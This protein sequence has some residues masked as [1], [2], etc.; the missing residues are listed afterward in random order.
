MKTILVLSANPEGTAVLELAREV[1]DIRKAL[2]R[3]K[4][5]DDFEL[6]HRAEV[7]WKDFR[8]AIDDLQPEIVHFSGHGTGKMGIQVEEEDRTVRV[9]SADALARMFKSFPCVK[10]VVLNACYS[11]EQAIAIHRHVPYVV[12]MS[13]SIGDRAAR[14]FAEAFYDGLFAGRG[15]REAFELG[16]SGMANDVEVWTPVLLRREPMTPIVQS[17]TPLASQAS[18]AQVFISYRSQDPD[19]TLAEA[20]QV[21]IQ[22][23][24]FSAFM[25]GASIRLGEDWVRRI[26]AELE[27]CEYFLLLLSERSAVSEMVTEEVRRAKQLRDRTGKP[28]LLPIRVDFPM[29]SP[30]NYDLRGYL[31]RIQQR[32][33]KSDRDTAGILTEILALMGGS[34]PPSPPWEGGDMK[35]LE[36]PAIVESFVDRES[37]QMPPLPV[38]EPELPGGQVDLA[39]QFYVE[40]GNERSSIE[41]RCYE[42]ITRPGALI[43]IKAPR[44]M[45]K[46]SLMSRILR[47]A[48]QQG[49]L[50]VP[51]SFQIADSVVF[52]DLDRF[53]KWFAASVARRLKLPNKL[54]DYWDDVFGSKDNCTAYFEEYILPSLTQPLALCLDEVDMVF[55]HERIAADFFGLLRNWHEMGKSSDLWKRFRLVVVHST[56]VYIPMNIN[57]SPFNVGLPI[58]LPEFTAQQVQDLALRHGL[59]WNTSQIDRLMGMVGGHPYLV[60]LGLYHVA[61]EDVSLEELLQQAP[62][63][64]GLYADHLRRHLWNLEQHPSLAAAVRRLVRSDVPVRLESVEAFQ[65]HSMG[66][67]DLLGNEVTFRSELYRVYFADRLQ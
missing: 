49:C 26:D 6:V 42:A 9:V 56:E 8:R 57:Q 4:L 27:A 37:V 17:V 43:R 33:W 22:A 67:V 45:G 38:A 3:S 61:R 14:E 10:C 35:A 29:D 12:G 5:Q 2:G 58:E 18:G 63:E 50:G 23:A 31:Q 55:Q 52:G 20:F 64:A 15:Y 32:E 34:I 24:G 51:L 19:R 13:L 59:R 36:T 30:L 60:R 41:A 44:Q 48:E 47:Y 62:T 66:L 11:E 7:Q 40:R 25:A 16:L 54:N 28:M 21:G 39:S 65:L 53:L 1:L 46:T